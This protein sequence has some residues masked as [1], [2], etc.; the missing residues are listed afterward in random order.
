[1]M[2][3]YEYLICISFIS[4]YIPGH[5]KNSLKGVETGSLRSSGPLSNRDAEQAWA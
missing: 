1:M 2:Y 3:Y 5:I 4:L